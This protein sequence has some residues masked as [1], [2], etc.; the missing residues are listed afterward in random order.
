MEH[1][2]T[3]EIVAGLTALLLL[4][5][6]TLALTERLKFPFSVAL[7]LL[8]IVLGSLVR[9]LPQVFGA[10]AELVISADLIL[11]VFL[12]SLIF[13]SAIHLDWRALKANLA[14][15]LLLAVPGL[16]LSTGLI[17]GLLW[18]VTDLPL[19]ATLLLG[20]ILSATDPVAV[21]ALFKR[22]GAPARLTVLVEGESLFNDAT[23]IVLSRILIGIFAAGSMS[24]GTVV[25]GVADFFLVFCGGIAT[26]LVLAELAAW[27]LA[28]VQS[29]PAIEITLTTVLAY[30]S[31]LLAEE[32][33]HVSGVMAT[34]AAGL[35]YGHRGWMQV[36]VSVRAY[37]HHF[38]EYIGFVATALIF[39]LVGLNTELAL[40]A[41]H[42]G[43]L[44]WLIAGMLFSRLVV[45][46][47]LIPLTN[48]LPGASPVSRDYQAVMYWG[49]LRG[50]IAL[51]IALS[52][53]NDFPY[54]QDFIALVLGAVLFTL[55]VQGVSMDRL[56]RWLKLDRRPLA[57]RH[58]ALESEAQALRHALERLP[59]LSQG[60]LFSS[61]TADRLR[62]EYAR[63]LDEA[64]GRLAELRRKELDARSARTLL[65]LRSLGEERAQ[66]H[67]LYDHGHLDQ[68]ALRILAGLNAD[69]Q[70]A[71]RH[72]LELPDDRQF[73][74]AGG[75]FG[76]LRRQLEHRMPRLF[77]RARH[78]RM[79]LSYQA[80]WATYQVC[81]TVLADLQAGAG[82]STAQA[83]LLAQYRHWRAQ[84]RD[85]LDQM[86]EQYPEFVGAMQERHARRLAVLA[87]AQTLRDRLARGLLD[88][89]TAETQLHARAGQLAAL[90]AVAVDELRVDPAELL[91]KVPLFAGM[92][93]AEFSLLAE[94]MRER[95]FV[96]G[97]MIL[98]QGDAG[99]SL[100]LIARGV[101]R[102]SVATPTGEHELA[103]LLAGD[104]FGEM[105]LLDR[106]PRSASVRAVSPCTTYEL[107][108]TD[109]GG[110]L[111]SH[112]TMAAA[113]HATAARRREALSNGEAGARVQ[114][115]EAS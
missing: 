80:H 54:R 52:L 66:L 1:V 62:R 39:L 27:A 113:V 43:L 72:G 50:A 47:G 7:L 6:A 101:V 13:E 95:S 112:P 81:S 75:A 102:V 49:G 63:R 88:A 9:Q 31:F 30:L 109:F 38:W 92:A 89:S 59:Q 68:R 71:V 56:V 45:I 53:P 86:A 18:L 106:Q 34:L 36:S 93:A 97:E 87:E 69:L 46:Y 61:A 12:P 94:H 14:P 91:R 40:L 24:V 51:A 64:E 21:I 70:D 99:D 42:F 20:A 33:L 22:L 98:Q 110:V 55:L 74:D 96:A 111:A 100:F 105:A 78:A 10:L 85:F 26:G 8:G 4:A 77:G 41:E 84:A 17:G 5:A 57:D 29:N 32:L 16:L 19:P 115:I 73:I 3:P 104:Y 103:T 2:A 108:G 25:S 60:G 107:Q 67:A 58:G 65:H 35:S 79:A 28:R 44:S 82:P 90:R 15:V 48:R 114:D 37:L 11:F 23:S 76:T 83:D